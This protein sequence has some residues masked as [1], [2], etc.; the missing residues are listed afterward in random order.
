MDYIRI[1]PE[2]ARGSNDRQRDDYEWANRHSTLAQ[3]TLAQ[4]NDHA[5]AALH[6]SAASRSTAVHSPRFTTG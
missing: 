2:N 3:P 1:R 6:C 4:H 5:T